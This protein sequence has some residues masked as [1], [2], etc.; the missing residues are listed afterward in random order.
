MPVFSIRRT[1]GSHRGANASCTTPGPAAG[2]SAQAREGARGDE[3]RGRLPGRT[4]RRRADAH[5]PDVASTSTTRAASG[6][7]RRS[8]IA[9]TNFG[10]PIIRKEGDR[11]VVLM[12]TKGDGK[13]DEATTFYQGKDLYGPLG[14]CVVAVSGRQGRCE[15]VRLPVA[16]HPRVRGQGRRPEGRR[17]AE[18]VPHRLPRLRPRPRR[19]RHHHRPGR[20]ALLHRRRRRASTACNRSDGKGRK[21]TSRT[22]PIARRAPSGAATWTA[23][24]SN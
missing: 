3:G 21:W 6:C 1:R 14:I 15:G 2:R 7:A 5:Q 8:T 9:A 18:E 11:I 16:G 22:T 12:D 13:A 24:T 17:P 23:R 20:Q 4:L 10:R 19:P